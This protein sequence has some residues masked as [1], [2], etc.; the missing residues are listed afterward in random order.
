VYISS[1]NSIAAA[2]GMT[3]ANRLSRH[4]RCWSALLNIH[5]KVLLTG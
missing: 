3:P 5:A 2:K 4:Q 1:N